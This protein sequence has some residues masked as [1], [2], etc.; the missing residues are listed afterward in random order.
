MPAGVQGAGPLHLPIQQV[1][2]RVGIGERLRHRDGEFQQRVPAAGPPPMC[3]PGAAPTPAP[4]VPRSSA[5]AAHAT[6]AIELSCHIAFITGSAD[7]VAAMVDFAAATPALRAVGPSL[8][9]GPPPPTPGLDDA[10]HIASRRFG[11]RERALG[12]S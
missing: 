1:P 6:T 9:V 8:L 4:R 12:Q 5:S 3:C 2:D 10:H 7:Q 11:V